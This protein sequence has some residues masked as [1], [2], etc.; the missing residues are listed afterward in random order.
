MLHP[1]ESLQ[2]RSPLMEFFAVNIP[3]FK[4]SRETSARML[5]TILLPLPKAAIS[6]TSFPRFFVR[7]A[8]KNLY[9]FVNVLEY[10]KVTLVFIFVK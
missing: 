8:H 9:L 3:S 10:E 6:N 1:L 5:R 7:H 2:P 4:F